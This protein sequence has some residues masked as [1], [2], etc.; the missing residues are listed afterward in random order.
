MCMSMCAADCIELVTAL[1]SLEFLSCVEEI[2]NVNDTVTSSHVTAKSREQP[3]GTSL[4]QPSTTWSTTR[5]R[6]A[7]QPQGHTSTYQHS[8]E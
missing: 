2:N 3:T 1:L 4:Q 5:L 6:K 8:P 7:S